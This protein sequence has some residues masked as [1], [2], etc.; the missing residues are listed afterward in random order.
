ML[1]ALIAFAGSSWA[2]EDLEAIADRMAGAA[3]LERPYPDVAATLT[4]ADAYRVQDSW[5][6]GVFGA[7]PAGFKAGLTNPA[8]QSRFGVATPVLG[9]LPENSRLFSKTTVPGASGLLIEVEIGFLV[10]MDGSPAAMLGVVELPRLSFARPDQLDVNDIIASNVSTFRFV[11]GDSVRFDAG[12]REAAVVL[13]RD[14]EVLNRGFATDAMGDPLAAYRWLLAKAEN[15]GYRVEPG[16][17]ILTGSLGHVVD[18]SPGRYTARFD[19]MGS[20]DFE[21]SAVP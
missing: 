20:I 2:A 18:G 15:V 10:G 3:L 13:E 19:G 11:T 9:V 1:L 5:V 16:M 6:R 8:A 12:V 7:F 17:I 21:I 4:E 14:G